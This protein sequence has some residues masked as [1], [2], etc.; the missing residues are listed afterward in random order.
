MAENDAKEEILNKIRK[1]KPA[2]RPLPEVPMYPY[3]DNPVKAFIE[4]LLDFDGRVVEFKTRQAALAW[5]GS[6]PEMAD[7]RIYSSVS[8]VKGNVTEEDIAD[9]RNAQSI[10]ICITEGAAGV[11]E[12]GSVWVTNTSLNHAA[13]AL[14][15]RRLFVLLDSKQVIGSLHEAYSQ[16][17]LQKNQYGSFYS[18]PSATADIE[19]VHITGAQGPLVFTVLLYNCEDAQEPPVLRTK[20]DADSS[21]WT[22]ELLKND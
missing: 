1:G 11:G 2:T 13:C 9:L 16:I 6:N 3:P 7:A 18:G 21:I 14:L 5:L 17:N 22:Q 15:A 20:P 8:D 12:M 10:N 19:A 4:H